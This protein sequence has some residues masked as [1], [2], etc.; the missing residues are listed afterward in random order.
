MFKVIRMDSIIQGEKVDK[1]RNGMV[2]EIEE[3][4][5]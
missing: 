3:I 2:E 4:F 5:T 1:N